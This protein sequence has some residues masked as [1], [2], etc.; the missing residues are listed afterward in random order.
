MVGGD[1]EGI[2]VIVLGFDFGSVDYGEA[3][4][5]E[6]LFEFLLDL[7]YGMQGAGADAGGGRGEI[8]PLGFKALVEGFFLNRG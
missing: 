1:V 3:E 7:R 5:G 8:D 2:E 6:E 4:R